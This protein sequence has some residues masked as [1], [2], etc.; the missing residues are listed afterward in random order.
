MGIISTILA[1]F[2][3]G[4]I[5][6]FIMPGKE[7]GGF[8]MTTLLGILG[9]MLGGFLFGGKALVGS[10]NPLNLVCSVI[11]ALIVLFLYGLFMKNRAKR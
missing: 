10:F 3:A 8:V 5:A 11:G 6:K 4:L 2:V 1:G 9:A 7:G